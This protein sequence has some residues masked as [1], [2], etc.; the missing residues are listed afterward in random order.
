MH[1][2][3]YFILSR[4][5]AV[6]VTALTVA[7]LFTA[8]AQGQMFGMPAPEKG[9]AAWKEV[10]SLMPEDEPIG[11]WIWNEAGT[12]NP[13]GNPSEQWLADTGLQKS[14]GKLKRAIARVAKENGTPSAAQFAEDIGWK[15]LGKAGMFVVENVSVEAQTGNGTFIVRL[16]DDEKVIEAFMHDLMVEFEVESNV[17]GETKLY[18]MPNSPIPIV[19][20]VHSG[21][22]IAAFGNGQWKTVA[23][24]IE[25]ENQTPEWLNKKLAAVPVSRRS[26]FAFGNVAA[27]MELLPP[28]VTE[29]PEFQKIDEAL[30]LE[31]IKSLSVCSGTDS[32]SNISMMHF[33]C[34]KEGLTSVFDVSA[35]KKSKLKEIPADAI[36]AIA[37]R[38]SPE[39]V[40]SLIEATVPPDKLEEAMMAFSKESGLDVK[41]DI[42]DHL[43]GTIRYYNTG[44][45]IAPKQIGIVRIKDELKFRKAYNQINETIEGLAIGEGFEFADKEKNGLRVFG[46][47]NDGVSFY[48]A[49]SGG[50][51]YLSNNSRAI[52]SHIRKY[53]KGNK[54]SLLDTELAKKILS[55]SKTMGLEGPIMMQ[56]YDFDQIIEVVVPL[57]QGAFAFIPA[58]AR[59]RFDFGAGDLPPIESLLGLRPTRSMLFK[60]SSGYTGISR[61]DTP[62]PMELS[63]IAVSGVAVGMLLPAVQATREAARRTQS[64]NNQRQLVLSLLNYEANNGSFPPAYTVDGDGNPLLSWRVA[65]LPYLDQQ[66]LFDQFHQDEPWDSPHNITLLEQ[67]PDIFRNP[68]AIGRPGQTDY[69]APINA[70]S[71]LATGA[72]VTMDAITDGTSGTVLVMEVGMDQQVP[73]SSPQDLEIDSLD[74]LDIDNGHP[75][76]VGIALCDGSVHSIAKSTSVEKFVKWCTKSDGSGFDE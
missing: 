31:G 22:L 51:L 58:E 6:L 2:K 14:F 73:W 63:T 50:E 21:N 68:S 45:V 52:G 39:N 41:N 36:A 72:G 26:Q 43:E 24:R 11:C 69:V 27:L 30:N 61:Y 3:S 19:V 62:A 28:V 76:T 54:A 56:H 1:R 67:M 70:D 34:D 7:V 42:V 8:S 65:I 64:M 66:D 44:S 38:F 71:I 13:E 53:T 5:A 15:M 12:L 32:V 74:S 23:Q 40:M 17:V 48:W 25:D 75:G 55:E 49:L 60:A 33:E 37:I 9:N 18:T 10:T 47:K 20:G 4:S 57:I 29:D 46:V 59:D 16:G 35:I